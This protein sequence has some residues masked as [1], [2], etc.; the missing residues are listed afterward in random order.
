[1]M[2]ALALVAF[3]QPAVVPASAPTSLPMTAAEREAAAT[4]LDQCASALRDL[5]H[6]VEA[7][8]EP[9]SRALWFAAGAVAVLA[10][11]YGADAL[12]R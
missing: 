12:A 1:M 10:V 7:S 4:A 9:P 5:A 11:I 8:P 2:R 3:L 6:E